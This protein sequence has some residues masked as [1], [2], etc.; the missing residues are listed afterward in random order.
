MCLLRFMSVTQLPQEGCAETMAGS[1]RKG[2]D[3]QTPRL[4]KKKGIIR[5]IARSFF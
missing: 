1:Y 4:K 3:G 2:D 5:L